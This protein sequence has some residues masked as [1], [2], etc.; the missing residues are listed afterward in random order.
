MWHSIWF[1]W[2]Y[3]LYQTVIA[4]LYMIPTDICYTKLWLHIACSIATALVYYLS[5]VPILDHSINCPWI[6]A[7]CVRKVQL[8]AC[9][10]NRVYRV[11]GAPLIKFFLFGPLYSPW[12]IINF[13]LLGGSNRRLLILLQW[14]QPARLFARVIFKNNGE[15]LFYNTNYAFDGWIPCAQAFFCRFFL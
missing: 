7:P 8:S 12:K 1:L 11:F 10:W 15:I 4:I 3:I 5:S 6:L 9:I 13:D 14:L 2:I